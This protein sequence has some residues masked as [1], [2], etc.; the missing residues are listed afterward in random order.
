MT[1]DSTNTTQQY[2]VFISHASEDKADVRKFAEQ[3]RKAGIKVWLDEE[4]LAPGHDTKDAVEAG[5]RQSRHVVLWVTQRWVDKRWTQ[6]ELM[7]FAELPTGRGVIPVMHLPWDHLRLGPYLTWQA[8][9]PMGLTDEQRLWLTLC[10]IRG[11]PPGEFQDWNRQGAR[12]M[13]Q[14]QAPPPAA[15][16]LSGPVTVTGEPHPS[17]QTLLAL[18]SD[19]TVPPSDA[20]SGILALNERVEALLAKNATEPKTWAEVY[21]T[22]VDLVKQIEKD[23]AWRKGALDEQ[24]PQNQSFERIARAELGAPERDAAETKNRLEL[25]LEELK[26]SWSQRLR[27][28]AADQIARELAEQ[29]AQGLQ[30]QTRDQGKNLEMGLADHVGPQLEMGIDRALL[31]WG[32]HMH[33]RLAQERDPIIDETK[34][35]TLSNGRAAA[36]PDLPDLPRQDPIP[37]L[38]RAP[39]FH[40]SSPGLAAVANSGRFWIVLVLIAG[41]AGAAAV[42]LI[43]GAMP[44]VALMVGAIAAAAAFVWIPICA[45]IER[46]RWAQDQIVA[47]DAAL[48][49]WWVDTAHTVSKRY[50][51]RLNAWL[52]RVIGDWQTALQ[53][54]WD[55]TIAKSLQD[56]ESTVESRSEE[57]KARAER[58]SDEIQQLNEADQ[59]LARVRNDLSERREAILRKNR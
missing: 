23:T 58:I 37:E 28:Q 2:D 38:A 39:T 3:L 33:D 42:Q 5:L 12:A 7:V 14:R 48:K 30:R 53:Q 13:G 22:G 34:K 21:Q 6:W 10:G 56:A 20:A 18:G 49:K 4:Q 57:L 8:R 46:R 35:V 54:W 25:R 15:S 29:G 51:V 59:R 44:T 31:T 1:T 43:S 55:A 11:T 45:E 27:Q 52:D 36:L 26:T 24:L 41:V 47:F 9:I 16:T 17:L 19:P 32:R 50:E 40:S